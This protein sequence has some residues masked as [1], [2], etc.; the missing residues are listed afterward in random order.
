M[1]KSIFLLLLSLVIIHNLHA[2][3]N[4]QIVDFKFEGVVLNGVLNTPK[5]QK[6]KGIVLIIHGSGKTNAVAQNWYSD[7]RER[8]VQTGYTTYMWDK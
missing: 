7:I 4:R 6:S 3:S 5:D 8:I 2:Q 1:K